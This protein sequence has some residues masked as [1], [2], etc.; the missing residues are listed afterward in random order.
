MNKDIL[1]NEDN[2]PQIVNG[3]FVV[4][5]SDEQH[6]QHI[7]QA[8]KG[9][10]KE[11]PSLGVD[12]I[13]YLKGGPRASADLQ[14]EITVQLEADGYSDLDIDFSKGLSDFIISKS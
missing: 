10:Y 3:D 2:S 13:R 8:Q 9:D 6:V 1:L 5:E 12:P 11:F 7:I 4:G 14:R